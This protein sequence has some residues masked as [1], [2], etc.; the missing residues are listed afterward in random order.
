MLAITYPVHPPLY[1]DV[2]DNNDNNG[3]ILPS[4]DDVVANPTEYTNVSQR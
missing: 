1:E 4:Y 3:D 2:E